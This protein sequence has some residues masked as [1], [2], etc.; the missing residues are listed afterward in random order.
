[1]YVCIDICAHSRTWG[2]ELDY[3]NEEN[4]D[5]IL[6]E[7]SKMKFSVGNLRKKQRA[8][9]KDNKSGAKYFFFFFL[10]S[11]SDLDLLCIYIRSPRC[12]TLT[13]ESGFHA[14][15]GDGEEEE[16][17]PQTWQLLVGLSSPSSTL[18]ARRCEAILRVKIVF[19]SGI[20]SKRRVS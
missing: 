17:R 13:P 18:I 12:N 2:K 7:N 8:T 11:W 15:A 20:P 16:P 14:F 9:I 1:M 5:R 10:F 3:E 4:N 6:R 19:N